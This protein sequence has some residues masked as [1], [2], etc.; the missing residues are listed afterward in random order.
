LIASKAVMTEQSKASNLFP[1]PTHGQQCLGL[2]P[3]RQAV[4][5]RLVGHIEVVLQ[6]SEL[7]GHRTPPPPTS[8]ELVYPNP[9]HR[10]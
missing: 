4:E 3:A 8:V 10:V 2:G 7:A 6:V 9:T 5:V 1:H